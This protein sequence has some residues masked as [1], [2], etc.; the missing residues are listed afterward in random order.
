[1]R[2]AP[3]LAAAL[4]AC[5]TPNAPERTF[6]F[7]SGAPSAPGANATAAAPT[8]HY[9]VA[10]LVPPHVPSPTAADYEVMYA[11]FATTGGAVGVYT[12]WADPNGGVPAVIA[13]TAVAAKQYGFGPVVI[14]LG[15][16]RDGTTG[17]VSTVDWAS[18]RA[19]FVQ[20]AA[21]IARDQR[22]SYLALGVE[23]NRLW[24][25][26]PSAF[27]GFVAGYAE[28]YDEIKKVSPATK[29]FTIFQLELMRG[30][31]YILTGQASTAVQWSLLD[32]FRGRLDLVGFT[33]YPFLAFASPKEIPDDYY[34][35]AMRRASLP[36]AFTE[37]G[38]PSGSIAGTASRYDGTPEEQV[39]FITRFFAL[40]AQVQREVVLWSFPNEVASVPG[41]PFATVALRTRDGAA[42][43][44]LAA[45]QAAIKRP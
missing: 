13:S 16:A 27:D 33:T 25:S 15:V 18:Q 36:V 12:N 21:S 24:M 22:P 32:R 26:D 20:T 37:V 9:G 6:T 1:M 34:Q 10:G 42:K 19:R 4:V 5:T 38:W 23:V 40:T 35:E 3:L 30:A 29:V 7:G 44:A 41:R 45:W 2:L 31:A 17:V 8:T 28:A 14:A 39:E 11:S 43:P